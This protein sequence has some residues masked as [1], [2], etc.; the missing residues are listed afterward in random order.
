MEG[1]APGS[2]GT[3]D[4]LERIASNRFGVDYLYPLQRL[5]VA[6]ILD[7]EA[8][9]APLRQIAIFPTGFGKSLCFQLPALL[10][11]GPTLAVYPLLALMEDQR[12]RL[13]AAGIGCAVF[14]GGME[15]GERRAAEEEVASGRAK[16]ILTN[17]ESLRGKLID[18]LV[19][20]GISHAAIDEAHC[21]SEW[22]ESFRP[23]YLAL[24]EALARLKPKAT[25]AFTAT[26]SPSI[27]AAVSRILFPEGGAVLIEGDPDRP[28]I[29][30]SVCRTL[31]R[32][33]SLV[34]LLRGHRKPAI[35]FASSRDGAQILA[36]RL[37]AR[38]GTAELRFYHAGLSKA[39]KAEVE[40]WFFGSEGGILTSTC[41]YGLGMDKKN[42]R[43]VI[44]FDLPPSVE[45][46]L[47]ESGR[48]GRDGGPAEAILISSP[49]DS[50]GLAREK[51]PTRRAR[52]EALLDYA[53]AVGRCRREALL[54]M[55][56]STLSSPCSGCDACDG[57]EV[58][59]FAG[60]AELAAFLRANPRRFDL[61]AAQRFLHGDGREPPTGALFGALSGWDK[62]DIKA[63]LAAA[64][65]AGILRLREGR[66]WKGRL[67]A[68]RPQS[69]SS[70][71][72]ASAATFFLGWS[73][74]RGGGRE[75]REL[76]K[77]TPT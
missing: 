23:A 6:N 46:Y 32:E 65:E 35:V 66:P 75:M 68:G 51:D 30:Y 45:A 17:P 2:G 15:E 69:S 26:A 22:G 62:A 48:A 38:L 14:R 13:A 33:W 76:R 29:R 4:C 28:N 71:S 39:E 8:S 56:G 25:T 24:G 67:E 57:S 40:S 12:R 1:Q 5:V 41:A 72:G 43:T 49:W 42:I 3:G 53:A 47:Q 37:R 36:E 18:F 16:I 74:L 52:K 50:H 54:G 59:G 20:Q 55:L 19:G 64:G 63:A 44:H 60:E 11:P 73:I 21:V 34:S 9:D 61:P 7:Q 58:P 70:R 10:L 31:A 77:T 27:L